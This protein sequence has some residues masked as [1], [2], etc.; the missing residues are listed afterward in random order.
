V[1]GIILVHES[2]HSL[3]TNRRPS[4]LIKLDIAKAYD[5]LNWQYMRGI[6]GAFGFD[7]SWIRWVMNLISSPFYSILLNGSPTKILQASRGIRQGDPLSP[8]LFIMAEGLNR[9]LRHQA[10]TGSL[11]GLQLHE[12]LDKQVIQQFVD[13]T[14]LMGHP[15]IQEARVVKS[16]LQ[17]FGKASG[18]EVNPLKSQ[19]FFF[20]TPVITQRNIL[21]ILGYPKG[22][23]PSKYLGVPLVEGA[24]KK[25]SWQDLV[26]RI[27]RRLASWTLR[28][29]NLP[30][31]LLLIKHVLQAMPVYLFSLLSAPKTV[32]KALRGIQRTF[33]W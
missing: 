33:L 27:R 24:V 23:F 22:S 2:I 12:G 32:L 16:C 5:K 4:M 31:R 20:N 11:R 13:D 19:V 30:S 25:V 29:L 18:L 7:R 8:F 26:D 10:E 28:P 21:R 1:D 15:S 9:L 6:L 17:L 3:K 14:M